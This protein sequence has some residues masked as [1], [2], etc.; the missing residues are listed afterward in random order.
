[1]E[2][3]KEVYHYIYYRAYTWNFF[4][5]KNKEM[6]AFNS[7]LA[8]SFSFS[9]SLFILLILL[10]KTIKTDIYLSNLIIGVVLVISLGH[11]YFFEKDKFYLQLE[12]KFGSKRKRDTDWYLKGFAVFTYLVGSILF[13]FNS[14]YFF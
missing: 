13:Y 2:S 10:E 5:W 9:C 7:T 12:E 14:H 11:F 3:I 4:L 1:L 8:L 6:A